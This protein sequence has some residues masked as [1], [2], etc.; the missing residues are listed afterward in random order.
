LISKESIDLIRQTVVFLGRYNSKEEPIFF[1]T[2]F[3]V[4]I[5]NVLHLVI[6]K[7][8]I[9]NIK[10]DKFVDEN[11]FVFLNSKSG[12]LVAHSIKNLKEELGVNWVFHANKEVDIA[13]IPFPFDQENEIIK[14][15]P[16]GLFLPTS[17]QLHEALDVF[18]VSFQPGTE[19]TRKISPIVRTGT[20]SLMNEDDT[21][22]IDAATFPGN[23]GSPVFTKPGD[24]ISGPGD[25]LNIMARNN[26]IG[27]VG[28]YVPYIEKAVSDQ[29]GDVRV[30]FQE[31]TGLSMIW[32][33]SF[34]SEIINTKKFINQVDIILKDV[35]K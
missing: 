7:H 13:I 24:F 32:H 11:V 15:I 29:T 4:G 23:S 18:F 20:I 6:A 8:A 21:F 12:T 1:A 9:Y 26:F 28:K 30:V 33:V 34:I 25:L 35:G 5:K 2:G 22:Y 16:D 19:D 3:I 10:F 27:V 17:Y 31:N 14:A